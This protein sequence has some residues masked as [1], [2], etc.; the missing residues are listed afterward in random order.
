MK[1]VVLK[2]TL[3]AM[4]FL[5]ACSAVVKDDFSKLSTESSNQ[6]IAVNQLGYLVNSEKIAIVPNV[7]ATTYDLVDV[8]SNK[9]ILRGRLSHPKM[10]G[11][12]G[13]DTFKHAEFTDIVTSGKY[14]LRIKGVSDS[15]VFPINNHVYDSV[16][17]AALKYFYLNRSS[18][19][20]EKKYAGIYA[21][22]LGHKD[23]SVLYHLS[24]E[25]G[26]DFKAKKVQSQKGWYD[27][28]DYGKYVVNSG[29]ATYTLLAAF[30]HYPEMYQK[31]ILNIPESSDNVPDIINEALWN[32]EWLITM[33]SKDGGVYHKLTTLEWPGYEMPHED[34]RTRYLIGKTTAASL[35]FAATLSAASRVIAP[36][37]P[38][39]SKQYL[40]AA[41][42]AWKYSLENRTQYYEQPADVKSGEYGDSQLKDEFAWA[43]AE[44]F[45]TTKD[46]GFYNVYK[47]I[48]I[49][50]SAPSWRNVSYLSLSSLLFKAKELLSKQEY[51]DLKIKQKNLADMYLKQHISSSYSVAME[52]SDFVWGSNSAALNKAIVLLQAA[53]LNNN[54]QYLKAAQGLVDY[55][56]GRNPTGYSFVTGFGD[57]TPQHPHHRIAQ[58][59]GIT[60]PVPGMLVG[61]PQ[62]G[63]Q[64]EC[65][66]D[67]NEP[68]KSYSDSWCSYSTNEVAI[69]WNAPLV[70]TLG[71]LIAQ[72]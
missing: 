26:D 20:I 68:A 6:K 14:L 40:G 59:D 38:N 4:F 71:S 9:V 65:N 16:H 49:D 21:R 24:S 67:S 12:S 41:I 62:A 19:E 27:A 47:E 22:P 44:L 43:A 23:D 50:Y 31:Q 33:Q 29:I 18:I 52:K 28:G 46:K 15:A 58:S 54:S 35:N 63:Q 39:K 1:N 69:N 55:I 45:L 60:A 37:Y 17:T 5:S 70:Y 32:L 48:N 10:W 53:Q 11:N 8:N 57:K 66:Y 61:G 25:P 34:K 7:I 36:Y 42:K 64:D 30:E 13:N 3:I 72:Q 56:L 2:L 51:E